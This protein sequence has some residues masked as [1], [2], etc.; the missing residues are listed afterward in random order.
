VLQTPLDV[1]LVRKVGVPEQP[2]LA[3][4]A[5]GEDGVRVVNHHVVHEA[6]VDA[7][8]FERVAARERDELDRRAVRIRQQHARVPLSGK[9]AVIVDDGIATGSTVR[10][11]CAVAR[12]HGAEQIIVAAPVAPPST[13]AALRDVA[14]DVIV[15]ETPRQ[16]QAIGQFYDDFSATTDEEVVALL[17]HSR[18]PAQ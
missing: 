9:T 15:V 4:G 2:E 12:A 14:D 6:H 17:R 1:I 16:F 8:V 7:D 11:A 10:A 5:V 18:R 3:M 13:I